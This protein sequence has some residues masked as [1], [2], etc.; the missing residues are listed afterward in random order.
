MLSIRVPS[1]VLKSA[2]TLAIPLSLGVA[3]QHPLLRDLMSPAL[4]S[5]RASNAARFSTMQPIPVA[6][7]VG[8]TSGIGQG[9]AE[10][11]ARWTNG[12]AHIIIVGRNEG[13]AREII[14]RMPKPAS[15]ETWSHEFIQCDATLMKNVHRA[16]QEILAKH[17][18][19]NFLV[20][21]PGY[22]A[23]DG[24]NETSEGI[25]AKL[26]VHYYA[27]WKFIDELLPALRSAKENGEEARVA[28][29]YAASYAGPIDVDDLGLKKHYSLRTAADS[30][31]TYNDYMIEVN[32]NASHFPDSAHKHDAA[33]P[34][35]FAEQNPGITFT[36]STPGAVRTNLI[37]NARTSWMRAI[38]PLASV[39][40]YP[41]TVSIHEC[42]EYMWHG[43]FQREGAYRYGSKG[44]ILEGVQ[45]SGDKEVASKLWHHTLEAT[46]VSP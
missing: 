46:K 32:G 36:H 38:G 25:D 9:M 40:V 34:Q 23:S 21:S 33:C 10:N 29:V 30:G 11:L 43:L 8:G 37:S 1:R 17:S 28:S 41:F 39:L 18:K 45:Y 7:F 44:Q 22:F 35:S 13:A 16:S 27:R 6:V 14:G 12:T 31:G 3:L 2:A 19:I 42:A 20:M 5:L 26:A 15:G 4:T 24:R